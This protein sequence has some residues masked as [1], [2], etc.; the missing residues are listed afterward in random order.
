M[1]GF[2]NIYSSPIDAVDHA[3][4]ASSTLSSLTSMLVS[5]GCIHR[6]AGATGVKEKKNSLKI[7]IAKGP[8]TFAYKSLRQTLSTS[9]KRRGKKKFIIGSGYYYSTSVR[10]FT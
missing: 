2:S 1:E 9:T 8:T 7:S 3:E 6:S 10:D 5:G 4:E